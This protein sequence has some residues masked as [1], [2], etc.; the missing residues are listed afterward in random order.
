MS[1]DDPGP[2]SGSQVTSGTQASSASQLSANRPTHDSTVDKRIELSVQCKQQM[3]R[4]LLQV[5]KA[6][7]VLVPEQPEVTSKHTMIAQIILDS[8]GNDV[9]WETL[10]RTVEDVNEFLKLPEYDIPLQERRCKR[11]LED[12]VDIDTQV[13]TTNLSERGFLT[14]VPADGYCAFA[15]VSQSLFGTPVFSRALM[16]LT[17][18]ETMNPDLKVKDPDA[19]PNDQETSTILYS[20]VV[21]E[22]MTARDTTYERVSHVELMAAYWQLLMDTEVRDMEPGILEVEVL[23]RKLGIYVELCFVSHDVEEWEEVQAGL[24]VI[25]PGGYAGVEESFSTFITMAHTSFGEG[26][27]GHFDVYTPFSFRPKPVGRS[28]FSLHNPYVHKPKEVF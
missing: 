4:G 26:K 13:V 21:R 17:M 1:E 9:A 25:M 20:E 6:R 15:V 16:Y 18:V 10:L 24:T 19:D 22:D 23:S 28:R 27:G 11:H 3:E 2:G 8:L 12:E 14:E 5:M 7:G